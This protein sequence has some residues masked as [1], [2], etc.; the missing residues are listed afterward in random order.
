M[1]TRHPDPAQAAAALQRANHVRLAR[2]QIK[3]DVAVGKLDVRD[4]L[5]DPPAEC[6]NM[7]ATDLLEALPRWG[8]K[9]AGCA[10]RQ[11]GA[12][13]ARTLGRLTPRQRAEIAEL[14]S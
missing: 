3:R 10:V 14:V 5:E 11:V 13:E 8:E 2:A 1:D 4:L 7:K 6:L 9:R 12:S